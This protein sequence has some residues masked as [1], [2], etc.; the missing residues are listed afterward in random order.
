MHTYDINSGA[1]ETRVERSQQQLVDYETIYIFRLRS[2]Y[3]RV[4]WLA[5]V[6]G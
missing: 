6:R 4:P 1:S 3:F 5:E 2:F